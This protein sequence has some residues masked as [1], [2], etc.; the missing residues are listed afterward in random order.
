MK[1]VPYIK[2]VRPLNFLITFLSVIGGGIIATRQTSGLSFGVLIIAGLSA[3]LIGSG[4]NVI[5]D[6]FD[7]EIDK[8]NRPERAIPSGAISERSALIYS[9]V[10]LFS[11]IFSAGS[12]SLALLSIAIFTSFLLFLYSFRLKQLPLVGNITIAFLTGLVFI[13][14]AIAAGNWAGGIVPFVFAFEIN[15]I[16][17]ILKDIE[18]IEGDRSNGLK[19]LPVSKGKHFSEKIIYILTLILIFTTPIPFFIFEY[20]TVYLLL[21]IL[22][23]DVPLVYFLKSLQNEK[24]SIRKLSHSLKYLMLFGLAIMIIGVL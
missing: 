2:I 1:I 21:I 9:F 10:L 4:G 23:V 18:D 6:Y 5:N 11:G 19:T 16:R 12:I 7:L 17:E 22:L 3:A 14:A 20:N 13:Y 15:L 8:V 24:T